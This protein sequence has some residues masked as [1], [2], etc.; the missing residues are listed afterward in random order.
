VTV[1]TADGITHSVEVEGSSLF[2]V[3]A[4]ALAAFRNEGWT[5]AITPNAVLQ[6][7]VQLPP[8]VHSV[9]LKA[10]EK[11]IASPN[12]SP[13]EALVKSAARP[14]T[15]VTSN[16]TTTTASPGPRRAR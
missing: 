12:T 16:P 2:E 3:A 10:V 7:E 9:P 13:R 14:T 1:E 6:I 5:D 15:S 8:I 4:T 11:W